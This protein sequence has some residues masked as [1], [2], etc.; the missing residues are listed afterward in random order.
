VDGGLKV[1]AGASLKVVE[2]AVQLEAK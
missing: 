1:Q 2:P